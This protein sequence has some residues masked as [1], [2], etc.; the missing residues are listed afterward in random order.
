M[1]LDFGYSQEAKPRASL[2]DLLWIYDSLQS[3]VLVCTDAWSK[4]KN[5]FALERHIIERMLNAILISL[6][7]P[8]L[9]DTFGEC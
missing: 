6:H 5:W 4:N 8:K 1:N 3:T 7:C 2:V 9:S